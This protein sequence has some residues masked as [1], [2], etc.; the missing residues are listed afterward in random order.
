MFNCSVTQKELQLIQLKHKQLPQPILFATLTLDNQIKPVQYLVKPKTVLL[1]Q[2]DDCHPVLAV[3]GKDQ[4]SLCN[5]EKKEHI[6]FNKL[7]SFFFKSV[8]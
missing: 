2:K 5:N 4:F 6:I 8:D 7:D 3:F 1:S